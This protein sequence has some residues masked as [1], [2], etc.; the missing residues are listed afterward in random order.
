MKRYILL[1]AWCM[2]FFSAM[3]FGMQDETKPRCIVNK[4]LTIEEIVQQYI[5]KGQYIKGQCRIS[6]VVINGKRYIIKQKLN[7]NTKTSFMKM[8]QDFFREMNGTSDVSSAVGQLIEEIEVAKNKQQPI[9]CMY[10]EGELL[11][12]KRSEKMHNASLL[13]FKPGKPL[14]KIINQENL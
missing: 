8:R 4:P 10:E 5:I 1:S 9:E 11:L 2:L 12:F 13:T 7:S 14:K 3:N 6:D